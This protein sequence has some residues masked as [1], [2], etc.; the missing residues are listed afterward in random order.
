MLQSRSQEASSQAT[1]GSSRQTWS[2]PALASGTQ[3]VVLSSRL[4]FRVT[5][6]LFQKP[7]A[8]PAP[9]DSSTW[10]TGAPP[11]TFRPRC[12]SC[13]WNVIQ[14]ESGKEER[15]KS[16]QLVTGKEAGAQM[17]V[18]STD[19]LKCRLRI[20]HLIPKAMGR[21]RVVLKKRQTVQI[22]TLRRSLQHRGV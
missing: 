14:L 19:V 18:G 11:C 4:C 15:G 9:L 1:E 21:P 6:C 2:T 12:V 22:C 7:R 17:N 20:F 8:S 5:G 3:P 16:A 10:L 13:G